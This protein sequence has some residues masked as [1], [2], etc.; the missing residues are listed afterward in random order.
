MTKPEKKALVPALRFPEFQNME[1]W[2]EKTL[3]DVAVFFKGKGISKSDIDLQGD[4]PCIRY[5]E[6]YTIYGEI[7]NTVHS[8]TKLP[9][10]ELFLSQKNDVLIPSSGET[11]ID[12]AKASC[13]LFDGVALGSDLNVL[14][15]NEDG[16]FLSYMLNGVC[17][18]DIA[19]KA[20]GDA[21]VHLYSSQLKL[22]DILVPKEQ[23]QQKIA[24]CLSSLD[25][26]ITS[27]TQK[28]AALKA[29]K[30]GLMQQLF[31]AEG[32]TVPKLRFP[33]FRDG[34]EWERKKLRDISP[35]IF[36]GTHQTP[37]YTEKGV[38]FYSVENIVSRNKNKFISK[39]DYD[40][41]TK[42]NK[43][44]KEDILI[45]RIGSIGFSAVVTWDFEFSIY[46]T[47]AVVKKS[48]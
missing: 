40:L 41:A 35:S 47:L 13:I 14:R 10:S 7:I 28:L 22:L 31:P 39:E 2:E 29:H 27:Q 33:E 4:V 38:P 17:K 34:G 19:K 45:T 42:I 48:Q 16:V 30:K 46:V 26:L 11:K 5:G 20:Q 44:E 24:D 23:E 8:K 43:P 6:L 1:E 9:T 18:R 3:D 15:S 36:D 37:K 25:D 32:E 12:I 21:V